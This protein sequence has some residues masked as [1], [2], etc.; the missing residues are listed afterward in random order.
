[1]KLTD[2]DIKNISDIVVKLNNGYNTLKEY[3]PI[4]VFQNEGDRE[5]VEKGLDILEKKLLQIRN[6]DGYKEMKKVIKIKKIVK[7][8]E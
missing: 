7:E 1:M 5:K 6:A 3:T 4:M 8:D 2:N